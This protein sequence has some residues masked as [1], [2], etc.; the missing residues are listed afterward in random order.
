MVFSSTIFL[1]IFLPSLFVI[2]YN[3]FAKTLKYRNIILLLYSLFFYAWGEPFFVF[4][5]I[6]SIALNW[7]L[8]LLMDNKFREKRKAIL[9]FLL[10]I[11]LVILFVC[12][13]LT[14]VLDNVGF[15]FNTSNV[16]KISLPIGISFFSFQ[17]MSYVIDV[18]RGE[19][20]AE[21]SFVNFALYASMFPQ[22]VAG[23]IVRYS[24]ISTELFSRNITLNKFG[25]GVERFVLGLGKKVIIANNISIIVNYSYNLL[26]AGLLSTKMAWLGAIS[27][28]LQI[29]FDFSGYSDMA[30]GL[31]LMLGFE[32]PENFNYPYL[33][34]NV[35]EF[36]RRWHITLGHWFRDYIYIP[37]GGSRCSL[38]RGI[39]NLFIVFLLS[40]IWHGANWTFIIWGIYLGIWVCLERIIKVYRKKD[41]REKGLFVKI[42]AIIKNFIIL[43]FGWVFFRADS[44][45]LAFNYIKRM[46][47]FNEMFNKD[48][49]ASFLAKNYFILLL[50][51]LVFSFGGGEKIIMK[52]KANRITNLVYQLTIVLILVICISYLLRNSYNPFIY[53]NF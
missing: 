2:Y 53:Y 46:L 18:Y 16:L 7:K 12:K 27:Y 32:F 6:L 45:V 38:K 22:L 40:G 9:I 8:V 42:F 13:Y 20:A 26:D 34:K 15:V 37:L 28:S 44:V 23:P 51:G 31:G 11:N 41:F 52:M 10:G 17:I 3:P 4:I 43:T 36:W 25:Q 14:F 35:S 50:L 24:L 49:Y 19:Y 48:I 39:A 47:C 1:F 21:M 5:L 33:S 29:Y 30:I